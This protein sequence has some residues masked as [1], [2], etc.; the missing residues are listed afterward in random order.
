MTSKSMNMGKSNNILPPYGLFLQFHFHTTQ[1]QVYFFVCF[2]LI[3]P[4]DG[5]RVRVY[6]LEKQMYFLAFFICGESIE[7][8]D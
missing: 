8:F 3:I 1:T 6:R 4:D 7:A 5:K 2:W